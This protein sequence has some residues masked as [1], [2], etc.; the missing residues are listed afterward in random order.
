MEVQ[1]FFFHALNLAKIEI[2]SMLG[3]WNFL[4]ET[5][6]AFFLALLNKV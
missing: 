2:F 1:N 5:L 6:T 3:N 4:E